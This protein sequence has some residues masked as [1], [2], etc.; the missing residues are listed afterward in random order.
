[1]Q[2]ETETSREEVVLKDDLQVLGRVRGSV[3]KGISMTIMSS[4]F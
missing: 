4:A 2:T 1:M 3:R